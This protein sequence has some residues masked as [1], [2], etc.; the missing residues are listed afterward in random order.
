M[1]KEEIVALAMRI[2]ALYL[3]ISTIG[4]LSA[5]MAASESGAPGEMPLAALIGVVII[6]V[7][8][9]LVLWFLPLTIAHKILPRMAGGTEPS[10]AGPAEYQAVA[11]SVLGM[12][13]LAEQLPSLFYWLGLVIYMH[14][15]EADLLTAREY[16][17]I[18]STAAALFIGFWLLFGA[19]GIV[20]LLRAARAAGARQ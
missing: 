11:F 1:K 13:V 12:W 19:R 14:G 20:G 17:R 9:A 6:P 15:Q 3:A 8:L 5:F 16:G 7:A 2:F 18:A 10:Q 4:G